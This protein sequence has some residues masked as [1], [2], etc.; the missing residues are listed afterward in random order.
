[1]TDDTCFLAFSQDSNSNSLLKD[2]KESVIYK[3][4]PRSLSVAVKKKFPQFPKSSL[5]KPVW[6]RKLRD[7]FGFVKY[8]SMVDASC[9]F[10]I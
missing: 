9:T 7:F 5:A 4:E 3:I 6:I 10:Y 8:K 2:G 1:M